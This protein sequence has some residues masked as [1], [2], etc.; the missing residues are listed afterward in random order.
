MH[1]FGLIL[2]LVL[3]PGWLPAAR[4]ADNDLPEG[5]QPLF[6]GKDLAGWKVHN[7][8]MTSWGAENGILFTSGS[9]GGWLITETG[10][11]DF[12]LRLAVKVPQNGNRG[13]ALRAP[14]K[15]DPAYEGMEIQIL[16]DVWHKA[17]LKGL[18]PTQLTGSIYDVVA[19]AKEVLKPIGQWNTY[20]IIAKGRQVI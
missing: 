11:G 15:G 12:E 19:P 17:N 6:N 7:G 20:R 9:Q 13:V 14:L 2:L 5:F 3:L 8:Q 18:R 16:D 1:R 4:T 10:Y